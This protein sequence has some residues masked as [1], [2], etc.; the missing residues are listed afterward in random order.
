MA[1]LTKDV[2][3]KKLKDYGIHAS[4]YS[5]SQVRSEVAHVENSQRPEHEKHEIII[6]LMSL[7][8]RALV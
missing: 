7:Y 5:R 6:L 8:T 3:V 1:D 4:D 2:I